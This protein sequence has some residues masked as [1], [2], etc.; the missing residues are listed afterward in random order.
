MASPTPALRRLSNTGILP[1]E[2]AS[3]VMSVAIT[4]STLFGLGAIK[5]QFGVGVWWKAGLEVS[6]IGGAAAAVAYFTARVVEKMVG[7]Q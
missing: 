3:F 1:D 7:G 5:S 2:F 4:G 6:G